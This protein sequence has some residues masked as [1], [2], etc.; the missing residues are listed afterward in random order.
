MKWIE[1]DFVKKKKTLLIFVVSL[2]VY[3]NSVWQEKIFLV[4]FIHQDKKYDAKRNVSDDFFTQDFTCILGVQTEQRERDKAEINP[5]L[6]TGIKLPLFFS[7]LHWI[8]CVAY[9][10]DYMLF[11]INAIL[12]SMQ[13]CE[14]RVEEVNLSD[15][16]FWM[17]STFYWWIWK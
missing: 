3:V 16:L 5:F 11:K 4:S 8:R 10:N 17:P 12:R 9:I 2:C 6:H 13:I 14:L 7:F 1:K 15:C